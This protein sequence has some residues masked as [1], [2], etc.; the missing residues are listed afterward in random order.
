MKEGCRVKLAAYNAA[1]TAPP[2][3]DPQEDYWK[4][5]GC[6]GVVVRDPYTCCK[7]DNHDSE[8]MV[9]VAFDVSFASRGLCCRET[10]ENSLWVS[11]ADLLPAGEDRL[12]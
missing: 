5:I 12:L 4:L 8:R 9:L 10:V 1:P 7:Y 11:I 2:G 6:E 3:C